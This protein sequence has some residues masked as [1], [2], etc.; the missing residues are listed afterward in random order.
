MRRHDGAW[1]LFS[2]RAVPI[3]DPRGEI[4]EWVGVHTDITDRTEAQE[5]LRQSE[6]RFRQLAE[7]MPQVVWSTTAGGTPDYV[8]ARWTELTGCDLA[9]TLTGDFRQGM[10]AEDLE[11]MERAA[12]EGLRLGE[13]Y[14]F[15]CRF[16]RIADGALRWHLVRSTPVRN[17]GGEVVKWLGT[18]TDIDE[19]KRAAEALR[20][21]EWRLRFTLDAANFGSW[22]LDL[23]SGKLEH[24]PLLDGIFGYQAPFREWTYARF[25]E[26]VIPEDR[27]AVDQLF[28]QSVQQGGAWN[29]ECRIGRASD[30]AI[31]W[32]WGYGKTVPAGYGMPRLMLGLVGDITERKQAEAA[33]AR[34][35]EELVQANT[36]LEQ[37]GYS[38]SHDLQEPLRNVMIYSELLAKRY[39]SKLD[40]EA[41][42][43][44]GYLKGG[45]AR[46]EM[47][48][49]DLLAYTQVKRLDPQEESDAMQAMADTV[50]NLANLIAESGARITYGEL[51]RVAVAPV[52]LQ[53]VLQNLVGNALKY[54]S[55][56]IP[57]IEIA[58]ERRGGQ[59]MFRVSDN[60]IGIDAEYKDRIFGLFKRL[61]S[62]K[63]YAGTGIGLAICLRIVERYGGR[64][65][66]ES[67][68]GKGSTFYFTLPV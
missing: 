7:S 18:S 48:V 58:A 40:G 38:A 44:I 41:L 55:E 54:R 43:I 47:L 42:E 39:G 6:E 17:A 1:R 46:M 50:A 30:G 37:F 31:R 57:E 22:E 64:I 24:S 26:H 45:A 28:E 34:A 3:F 21:S 63:E 61:H 68:I 25:L 12:A 49:R 16:R 53:Q 65:W 56:R 52:H 51:P 20:L 4:R 27:D 59:W 32:I 9:A 10:T 5:A 19:Q 67:E 62:G 11:T 23:S 13:P 66:V 2:I 33:L 60:G 36:D 15:E 8:N 29:F 35:N 14:S